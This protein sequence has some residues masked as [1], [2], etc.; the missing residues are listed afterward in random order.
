MNTIKVLK[1][2]NANPNLKMFFRYYVDN[3]DSLFSKYYNFNFTVSVMQHICQV[4]EDS[5]KPGYSFTLDEQALYILL[6]SA[7]FMN[8][9]SPDLCNDD[10]EAKA[11]SIYRMSSALRS[12]LND[13]LTESIIKIVTDNIKAVVYPYQIADEELNLYQRILRECS[14]LTLLTNFSVQGMLGFIQSV[15][16][17]KN[18]QFTPSSI[19]NFLRYVFNGVKSIKLNY[20]K[21]IVMQLM[22]KDDTILNEINSFCLFITDDIE[23]E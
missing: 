6:L 7:I 16:D 21:D 22:D 11:K 3:S 9:Y 17:L 10:I 20:V 5:H 12:M 8:F 1:Y 23:K 19:S 13:D 4:Y 2:I 14:F 18:T 15:D